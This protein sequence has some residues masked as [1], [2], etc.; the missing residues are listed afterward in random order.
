MLL[1]GTGFGIGFGFFGDPIITPGLQYV[2]KNF[3]QWVQWLEMRHTVLR[4]IPT[5][6]QLLITLLRIGEKNNAPLPPPPSSDEP[7]P[8]KPHATAGQDLDHLGMLL[9]RRQ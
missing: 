6:A 2:N 4:G 8:V 7:P 9:I 5:N 3:P 1:K